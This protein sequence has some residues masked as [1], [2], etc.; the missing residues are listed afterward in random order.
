M[1][2]IDLSKAYEVLNFP[3]H[4]KQAT[5]SQI[6]D[7]CKHKAPLLDM[8]T[9]IREFIS[10]GTNLFLYGDFGTGKS[11][12]ASLF[13]KAALSKGYFGLWTNHNEL[14]SNLMNNL[15]YSVEF[16]FEERC[17]EVPI[18]VIDEIVFRSET[19]QKEHMVE[20][21][22]RSRLERAKS[23]VVTTNHDLVY[24]EK[25]YKSLYSIFKGHYGV[26]E[27]KGHNFRI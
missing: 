26:M 21:I 4:F 25:T 18:L 14:I 6:P 22:L 23:T 5:L 15:D 13:L 3:A 2:E 20:M 24:F 16:T 10:A 8:L 9:N 1:R 17:L 12:A 11:A 19:K 7:R 27:F